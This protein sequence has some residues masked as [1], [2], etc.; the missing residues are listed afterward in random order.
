M[1]VKVIME[2]QEDLDV[3]MEKSFPPLAEQP[4]F[5]PYYTFYLPKDAIVIAEYMKFEALF[6]EMKEVLE[7]NFDKKKMAS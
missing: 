3:V 2:S 7:D 4:E 6:E 1:Q 5:P